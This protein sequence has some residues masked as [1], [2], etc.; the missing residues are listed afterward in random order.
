[1]AFGKYERGNCKGCTHNRLIVNKS[2][3]LCGGCNEKRKKAAKLKR[4]G[5]TG[6]E[7]RDL[8]LEIYDSRI[9]NWV[10][11]ISGQ[12]LPRPPR[13]NTEPA[14]AEFMWSRFFSCFSHILPK[15]RYSEYKLDHRNIFLV[16]PEEHDT[17]GNRW[18]TLK[19]DPAWEKKFAARDALL[20]EI[21]AAGRTL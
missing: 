16:T 17:W 19:D 14:K 21:A 8:F 9:D 2:L 20:S 13:P 18:K 5:Q 3:A 11:D 6:T 15:G 4:T 7:Q 12:P 1:M 10:S